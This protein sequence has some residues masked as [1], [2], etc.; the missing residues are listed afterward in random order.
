MYL[1]DNSVWIASASILATVEIS[2]AIGDDGKE[3]TPEVGFTHGG[4][5]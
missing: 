2:K 5:W 1:A 3:V 4:S